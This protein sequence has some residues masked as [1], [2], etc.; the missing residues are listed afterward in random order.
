MVLRRVFMAGWDGDLAE[1][2]A[3]GEEKGAAAD[4]DLGG[5]RAGRRRPQALTVR[6]SIESG[7]RVASSGWLSTR[8]WMKRTGRA[9][10]WFIHGA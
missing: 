4:A 8:C 6:P 5:A 2:R 10:G 1:A 9:M 7:S 3:E